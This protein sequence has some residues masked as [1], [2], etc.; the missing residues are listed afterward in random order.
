MFVKRERTDLVVWHCSATRPNQHIGAA[1]IREW[2]LAP[3]NSYADIGYHL[4]IP[5]SGDLE[6]GRPLDVIGAHVAGYNS[7][8]VG[9]CMVGGLDE[10]G[11]GFINAPGQYTPEQWK[12][13][14]LVAAFLRRLYPSANHV[15]HRDLSPDKNHDGKISQQEWLKTCPGFDVSTQLGISQLGI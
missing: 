4:I 5:R 2:H 11:R 9:V 13:A 6:L 3:P 1:Q 7:V 10:L 8:S 12:C 15:G 14:R